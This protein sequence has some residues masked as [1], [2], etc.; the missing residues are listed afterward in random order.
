MVLVKALNVALDDRFEHIER[1]GG[2]L[3]V[4]AALVRIDSKLAV[5]LLHENLDLAQREVEPV[6]RRLLEVNA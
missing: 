1:I 6:R 3:I 5:G 4:R 2:L